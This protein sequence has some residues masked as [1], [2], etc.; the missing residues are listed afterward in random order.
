VGREAPAAVAQT[1]MSKE[2]PTRGQRH[3]EP[4]P[5]EDDQRQP[6][7]P[8]PRPASPRLTAAYAR[9]LRFLRY[10]MV[11]ALRDP[12]LALIATAPDATEARG[13]VQGTGSS[14]ARRMVLALTP[15]TCP[16]C[17]IERPCTRSSRAIA[18]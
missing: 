14:R 16:M 9:S 6:C 3:I 4:R 11:P 15:S 5:D 13:K 8:V 2:R 12:P 10:S 17:A 18:T 7:Q 1:D